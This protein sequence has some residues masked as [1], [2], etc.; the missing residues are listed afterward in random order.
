V[1][2]WPSAGCNQLWTS[3]ICQHKHLIGTKTHSI[4]L[5]I[6]M[7][8]S[9]TW[10]AP[11][12]LQYRKAVFKWNYL[13]ITCLINTIWD[14]GA[15]KQLRGVTEMQYWHLSTVT[16]RLLWT[17]LRGRL[18]FFIWSDPKM[19]SLL[20]VIRTGWAHR[21]LLNTRSLTIRSRSVTVWWV[22]PLILSRVW[23]AWYPY[24][25]RLS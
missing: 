18:L 14:L 6:D 10:K 17:L 22:D 1:Q 7:M 23:V 8:P 2:S 9:T 21:W 24:H 4:L 20:V 16:T 12:W 13:N 11:G 3:D 5:S 15:S 25:N 19:M